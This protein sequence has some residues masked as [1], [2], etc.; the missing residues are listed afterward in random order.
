[1]PPVSTTLQAANGT[2]PYSW[3]VVSGALPSGLALSSGGTISG[4]P[5]KVGGYTFTVQVA[6][7][8]SHTATKI[9]SIKISQH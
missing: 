3:S 7:S 4:T 9:F 5:T 8:A 1:M 2:T 6:D